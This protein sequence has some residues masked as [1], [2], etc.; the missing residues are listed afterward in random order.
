MRDPMAVGFK[1]VDCD[2]DIEAVAAL[3]EK[4]WTEH[5]TAIIGSAQVEYMLENFQSFHAIKQQ[6]AQVYEYYL[7][8]NQE[9]PAGY[10]SFQI[11]KPREL[12]LSKIYV[13][14]S[15]RGRGYGRACIEFI[16]DRARES[17]VDAVVLTV[18]KNNSDSCAAYERWGF[19]RTR[20]VIADIGNG[21]VMDDWE[22][23]LQVSRPRV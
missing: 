12:F 13:L 10:F 22:Y 11:R 1:K 5:Y 19:E 4:I 14:K 15:E 21:F 9:I 2:T 23:R 7:V 20:S 18:N 17:G 3:A 16:S 8:M 6:I